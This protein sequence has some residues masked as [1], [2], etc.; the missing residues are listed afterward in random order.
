MLNDD[1]RA[2]VARVNELGSDIAALNEEIVKSKA[3]GDEPNDLMDRR[4]LLIEELGQLI[5]I[6]VDY[7]D[8]DEI[9]VHTGGLQLVQG[10]VVKTF[11]LETRS[12][13]RGLFAGQ[14]GLQ[15]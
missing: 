5:D 11:S 7:R 8:S 10:G 3:A 6:T 15:R 9:N 13:K 12:G 14:L 4:D 2:T 1:I